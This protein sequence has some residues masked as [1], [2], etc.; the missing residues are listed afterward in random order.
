[1]RFGPSLVLRQR[2]MREG[3]SQ[4]APTATDVPAGGP[5]FRERH[6]TPKEL[7]ALWRLDETTIR[8]IFQDEPDVLRLGRAGRRDK[9]DYVTLRI[10]QSVALRVHARL[11]GGDRAR[12]MRE[13]C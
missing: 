2:E 10:P 8:R 13:R 9:R 12:T 6:Y 3:H 7:A 11:T 5:A 1:M 4:G